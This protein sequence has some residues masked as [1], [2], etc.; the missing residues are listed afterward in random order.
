MVK[1]SPPRSSPRSGK[2][3]KTAD[4]AAEPAA[5]E[6]SG[7][8]AMSES[9]SAVKRRPIDLVEEAKRQLAAL[10]G[11]PVDSVSGFAR[12][13]DG[14]RLTATVVELNRIPPATE[15]LAEYEVTLD[16]AGDIVDYRRGRR[17]FRGQVG[18]PE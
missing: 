12:V 2:P 16:K 7:K 4:K 15:V 11:Y 8:G 3:R 17:Y 18:D 1:S 13:E 5:G 9:G 14:W 6:A 10:T